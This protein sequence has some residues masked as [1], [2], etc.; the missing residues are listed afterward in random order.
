M[1]RAL[2]NTIN[3]G[4]SLDGTQYCYAGDKVRLQLDMTPQVVMANPQLQDNRGRVAVERGPLVYC[5][6]QLDQPGVGS[7]TDLALTVGTEP[8]KEFRLEMRKD[9]LGGI[10]V[11]QHPGVYFD[12]PLSQEPLYQPFGKASVKGGRAVSLNLIPYY[13]WANREPSAMQ[14]WMAVRGR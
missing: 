13:A 12:K 1:E 10:V 2:Y 5:V 14:V 3:A 9:L 7:L 4:M 11:L 8:G 6:E